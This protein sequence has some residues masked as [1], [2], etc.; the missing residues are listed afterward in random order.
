MTSSTCACAATKRGTT[1]KRSSLRRRAG[2]FVFSIGDEVSRPSVPQPGRLLGGTLHQ[3]TSTFTTSKCPAQ[4]SRSKRV[5]RPQTPLFLPKPAENS[6]NPSIFIE[7][8]FGAGQIH[9]AG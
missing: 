2:H 4:V 8:R 6:Q 7:N 3:D 1:M 5:K 9:R